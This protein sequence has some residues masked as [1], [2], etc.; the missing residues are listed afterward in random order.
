MNPLPRALKKLLLPALLL[1]L[2]TLPILKGQIISPID[3]LLFITFPSDSDSVAVS[4]MR[5]GALSLDTAATVTVQGESR[6]IYPSG[7]VTGLVSLEP[8]WNLLPFEFASEV[9]TQ[10]YQRKVYRIPP[11]ETLPERPVRILKKTIRPARDAVY[12][13]EDAIVVRF[14]GSPGGKAW[15][16]I[17]NLT[18][19]RL[20]MVELATDNTG[21]LAGVY[22]GV[23]RLKPGDKCRKERVA[24]GLGSKKMRSQGRITVEQTGQPLLLKTKNGS[25]IVFYRPWGE[26]FMDLPA[27]VTLRAVADLGNWWKVAVSEHR[28]GYI[29][30]YSTRELPQ[31]RVW[32]K[33]RLNGVE[34]VTDS[35]W[36]NLTFTTSDQVPFQIVQRTEPQMLSV[37]LHRAT[38]HDEW[39]RYPDSTDLI[40]HIFWEQVSDDVVRFDV[41][42]NTTQQWGFRGFYEG[43]MFKLAIRQPPAIKR[44]RPFANLIIALDPGHG[45]KEWGAVGPTGL[46]EKDINLTYT[47][48]LAGLLEAAGAEV[49]I[50][51]PFD[52]TMTLRARVEKAREVGAH[53]LV[54]LHNNSVGWTREPEEIGGASMFYTHLQ[55]WPFARAVYWRL[56]DLDLI[57]VGT[58]HRSYYVLRQPDPV[59][60]LVEGA[61]LSN[62]GDEMFLLKDANLKR[63]AQAVYLG[64]EDYLK[65]LGE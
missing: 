10:F 7:A 14:Q 48:Y 34:M 9:D 12:F 1:N 33:A 61:F 35:S 28:T 41:Y 46:K 63:L 44:E 3:T 39:T 49:H 19:G 36:M 53:I 18:S 65:T 4:I 45:G 50:T 31:G 47:N 21:G 23:Y 11:A 58:V 55:G 32:P 17:P 38:F 22:E 43:G 26:I 56:L 6:K 2:V 51:R 25:N 37:Y 60:F 24:F 62:P 57:P 54:W 29:L 13:V 59:V 30:K 15:F 27:G 40:D 42:L 20:P 16:R 52:T 64:M 5:F 8:G